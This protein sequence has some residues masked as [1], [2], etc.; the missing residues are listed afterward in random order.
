MTIRTEYPYQTL[1]FWT[2]G[3]D[4][5]ALSLW[6]AY[7]PV[8]REQRVNHT[9]GLLMIRKPSIPGLIHV[10]WPAI[11]WFTE[12]IFREDR[13]I[14]EEEQRAFDAQGADWNQEIFPIIQ[15]LR[16]VLRSQGVPLVA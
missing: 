15:G 9:F 7:V 6:N 11:V 8:D 4:E 10:I 1:K 5:P 14:V 3:S 16:R 12:R 13:R 2:A